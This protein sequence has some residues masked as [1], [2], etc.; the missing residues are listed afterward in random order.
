MANVKP[1]PEGYYT[2]TPHITVRD[3]AKAIE[4]YRNA[5]G[6]QDLGSHKSPDG[7][8]MHAEIKIGN[9][10][11][12]L[13]DEFPE[14]GGL[15]PLSVGGTSTSLHIYVEDADAAFER[16]TKAGATVVMPLADMFWGDRYGVITDP[17]GHRWSLAT[18]KQDLTSEEI[19]KASAQAFSNK[20]C[21]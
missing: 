15:S 10:I 6:A 14:M 16:A 8:I 9:S 1:I 20:S 2:I 11:V 4:F 5:F 7:K 21:S 13:N 12:M 19:E 17:F 3:A 18:H